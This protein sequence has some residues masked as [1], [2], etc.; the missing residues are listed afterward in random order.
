MDNSLVEETQKYSH[1]PSWKEILNVD[2]QQIHCQVKARLLHI[3]P[4]LFIV[5]SLGKVG[6]MVHHHTASQIQLLL[7][8][9]QL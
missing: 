6:L 2:I 3:M 9:I 7:S 4:M 8:A 5:L 1:S